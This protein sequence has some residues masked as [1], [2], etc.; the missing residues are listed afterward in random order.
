M[1]V[2]KRLEKE[3]ET[4]VHAANSIIIVAALI[5]TVTF[6]VFLTPP[7]GYLDA[8][9]EDKVGF[10]TCD[11][12]MKDSVMAA[13]FLHSVLTKANRTLYAGPQKPLLGCG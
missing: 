4:Y 3:R 13:D 10:S 2:V 12:R 11:V 8:P 1:K 5:A 7:P 6:A 9:G